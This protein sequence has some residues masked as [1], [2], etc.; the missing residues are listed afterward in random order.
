MWPK[1]HILRGWSL[2]N[3]KAQF[4]GLLTYDPNP[5]ILVAPTSDDNHQMK[6]FFVSLCDDNMSYLSEIIR[7]GNERIAPVAENAEF[8]Q[9]I[10]MTIGVTVY[11][12]LLA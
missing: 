9:P 1:P 8:R 2:I 7:S 10:E 6:I 4:T 12:L 11:L 5:K 3:L